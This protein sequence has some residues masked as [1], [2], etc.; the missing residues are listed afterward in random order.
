MK[1]AAFFLI[2][3]VLCI[4]YCV[5]V[6]IVGFSTYFFLV[7]GFL[8]ALSLM[9]GCFLR[10]RRLVE[11]IPTNLRRISALLFVA[12]VVLFAVVEGFI[13]SQYGATPKAGA[14][15]MIILGAQW[16]PQ[17]PSEAL[18]R[19]L[20]AA[21]DYLE[22]NPDTI[23]IVSGGRGSDEVMSEAA[24]MSGYL[25]DRGISRDRILI[26]DR[27]SNTLENIVFSGEMFDMENSRVVIVTNN[28][29]VFRALKIAEK[30]GYAHAEG[31]AAG[32]VPAL[33]PNNLLREFAGVVKDF[34]AG[35]L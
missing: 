7:W 12:G 24:G 22:E 33:A 5:C 35:N 3:G 31:L 15:Y 4:I 27:S 14:D 28:F 25:V 26:E 16:K 23:V 18:K 6:A 32:S 30:Q 8:G 34:L 17:G 20:D 10:E 21:L 9:L 1:W 2:I 11:R 19:R 13:L 29:H